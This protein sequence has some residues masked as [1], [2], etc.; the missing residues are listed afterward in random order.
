VKQRRVKVQG[1][2]ARSVKPRRATPRRAKAAGVT[3]RRAKVAGV[4]AQKRVHPVLEFV[5]VVAIVIFAAA[6]TSW[7]T[8]T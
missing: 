2:N 6:V 5:M 3:P 4:K 8:I 1:V 7:L